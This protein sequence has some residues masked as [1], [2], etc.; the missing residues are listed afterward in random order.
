MFFYCKKRLKTVYSIHLM[1]VSVSKNTTFLTLSLVGQKVLSFSYF[2]MIARSLGVSS[3]GEY[4]LVLSFTTLF[5]I[6]ADFGFTPV[7]VRE[8]A[9]ERDFST[10]SEKLCSLLHITLIMKCVMTVF[11]VLLTI[12]VASILGYQPHI[13]L[14]IGIGCIVMALDSMH[15]FFYGILRGLHNVRYEALGMLAGQVIVILLGALV[16]FSSGSIRLLIGAL[17]VGSLLNVINSAYRIVHYAKFQFSDLISRHPFFDRSSITELIKSAWPFTL[18]GV[19]ARGYSQ[20]DVILLGAMLGTAAVGIYSVPSKMV[21][22]FQFVPLALSASLYPALS[23]AYVH[24]REKMTHLIE[25]SM[26]YL[27]LVAVPLIASLLFFGSSI[28]EFVFGASYR[29]SVT[30]L[31]IISGSILFGFLDI[32]VGALLNATGNQARQTLAMGFT[33]VSNIILNVLLIPKFGAVGAAIA[34]VSSQSILFFSGLFFARALIMWPY[35]TMVIHIGKLIIVT[36]AA[37]LLVQLTQ[38]W[39]FEI[40]YMNLNSVAQNEYS[41]GVNAI[42]SLFLFFGIY[43]IG[44]FIIGLLNKEKIRMIFRNA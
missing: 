34:A 20:L 18:A 35:K 29:G 12:A 38:N 17:A 7:I 33:L 19:L 5:S 30:P 6:F 21:F 2:A 13:I 10:F 1:S 4:A 32:P 8:V 27:S 41:M 3:T 16:L 28:I 25:G 44:A 26:E 43:I 14:L 24:S 37:L 36:G 39:F 42:Y 31:L 15:L 22:A 23:H 40:P 11:T 9:K